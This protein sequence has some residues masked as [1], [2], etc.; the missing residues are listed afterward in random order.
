MGEA[1]QEGATCGMERVGDARGTQAQAGGCVFR[2]NVCCWNCVHCDYSGWS[3]GFLGCP[4]VV[5]AEVESN[6][7]VREGY[8]QTEIG[9]IPE[10]WEVGTLGDYFEVTLGKMLSKAA[11][12]GKC[13]SPYLGNN[14]VQWGRVDVRGLP[15]MDF[16]AKEKE[17]FRLHVGD[18]LVC[19]GGE[20]GRTA[21]WMGKIEECYY[22]KAIHRL[23]ALADYSA[24]FLLGYMQFAVAA[25]RLAHFASQTSIAPLT[26]EKLIQCVFYASTPK[27]CLWLTMCASRYTWMRTV[28]PRSKGSKIGVFRS[29]SVFRPWTF[30]S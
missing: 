13:P 16:S 22:Q 1:G 29:R 14:A 5:M 17:K 12:H 10:S 18:L 8:K 21:R 28:A 11:R 24:K 26:R 4:G 7:P 30:P 2:L 9:E 23:R 20:I 19:E 27:K 15:V 6:T 3:L 25:S